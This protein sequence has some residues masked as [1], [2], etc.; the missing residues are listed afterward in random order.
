MVEIKVYRAEGEIMQNYS[1]KYNNTL[2][3]K[4]VA[5]TKNGQEAGF[6]A[7]GEIGRAHV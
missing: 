6:N 2:N 5:N 7:T 1:D 4:S 3:L